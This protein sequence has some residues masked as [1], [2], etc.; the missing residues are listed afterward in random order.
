MDGLP[1][2]LQYLPPDKTREPDVDI[3][4]MLLEGLTQVCPRSLAGDR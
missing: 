1:D 3:R 2:D 4:K